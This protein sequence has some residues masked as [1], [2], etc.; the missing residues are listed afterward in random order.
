MSTNINK[1]NTNNIK[2]ITRGD[3]VI[4]DGDIIFKSQSQDLTNGRKLQLNE[5]DLINF[6]KEGIKIN[7]TV[8]CQKIICLSDET[9]KENIS[10]NKDVILKMKN[11]KSYTYTFKT[12]NKEKKIGLL[13]QEVNNQFPESTVNVGET[14]YVDYNSITSLLVDCVNELSKK[15]E[16]LEKVI[17]DN[18]VIYD[19]LEYLEKLIR[20]KNT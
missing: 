19:K 4:V 11:L 6:N 15:V 9:K 12:D 16:K 7:G 14:V 5:D 2:R 3:L 10:A 8:T 20:M 13:A 1:F 17:E 18:K